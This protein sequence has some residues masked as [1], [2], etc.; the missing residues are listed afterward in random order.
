MA[1]KIPY[2]VY[3]LIP[4]QTTMWLMIKFSIHK[5]V[6]QI[7]SS[8]TLKA[9]IDFDLMKKAINEEIRRNDCMRLRFFKSGD[10][11]QQY[12]LP[13]YT[14]EDVP[15]MQFATEKEQEAF[16]N[17]DARKPVKF[18]RGENFRII[19]F[20]SFNGRFGIYF[21]T[22]H[23]IM[24]AAAIAIFYKD[25]LEVYRAMAKGEQL[26]EPLA[27][28]EEYIQEEFKRLS[29]TA[30][31][32]KD[33]QWFIEYYKKGGC[34]FY[35]GVHGHDLLDAAREKEKDPELRIPSAYDPINDK[36]ELVTRRIE[37]EDAQKILEF[38]QKNL[39]SPETLMQAGYRIHVSK[40][41]YN[42]NDTFS[43]Q[44][45][46]KRVTLK[47]KHMGGCLTQPMQVR[48]IIEDDASFSD[49]LK[50]LD[51]VRNS[52]YRH[53]TYPYVQAFAMERQMYG[54][55]ISQAPSFM[56]Y[57]WLPM[58]SGGEY[59]VE[60][61]GYC[62]GRY[63][64]PLY[65]FVYPDARNMS[66]VCTYMHRINRIQ[67][68]HIDDLHNNMVNAIIAGIEHPEMTIGEIKKIID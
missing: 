64:M 3:D 5:E 49:M 38:C 58:L 23:M 8:V 53:M 42:T 27:S 66:I 16:L 29:N 21:N 15:V 6:L 12:F 20:R 11:I 7:P 9:D 24:D 40:I 31:M 26:P 63:V 13:E 22:S 33:K 48:I 43:L 4:S 52:L 45:C 14:L 2:P 37:G 1:K 28:Y 32:E 51:S 54:L 46:S 34:P 61:K 59:D 19:L 55:K 62:I 65:T 67:T 57:T 35:A 41:N 44:L 39:V 18:L 30:K 68:H 36:A 60:F 10:D 56:M 50:E 47:E 17:K 25:L